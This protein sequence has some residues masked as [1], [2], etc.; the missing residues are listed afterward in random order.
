MSVSAP[1]AAVARIRLRRWASDCV[2][3]ARPVLLTAGSLLVTWVAVGAWAR[4]NRSPGYLVLGGLLTALL[5]QRPQ[6]GLL[7]L[8]VL[9]ATVLPDRSASFSVGGV[10][11]DAVEALSLLLIAVWLLAT[12]FRRLARPRLLAG[13]LLFQVA[14]VVGVLVGHRNGA[15]NQDLLGE[16][17]AYM[18]YTLPLVFAAYFATAQSQARLE[19]WVIA[20][21]DFGAAATML[22]VALG[23]PFI[24]QLRTG[25]VD[26]LGTSASVNRVISPVL[27]LITLGLLFVL[28]RVLERGATPADIARLALYGVAETLGFG[29]STWL[30]LVVGMVLLALLRQGK[31]VPLRGLRASIVIVVLSVGAY[32][33]AASG[34]LGPTAKA[35]A[36]RAAS[37]V[38]PKVTS[39]L[40]Y[41]D[42]QSETREAVKTLGTSPVVGVGLARPYGARRP[43]YFD[44]PPRIVYTDR[45]FV[46]NTYL[47]IW[48]RVGLLGLLAVAILAWGVVKET[49]FAVRT[50][51]PSVSTRHLAAALSLAVMAVSATFQTLL[52][53][54]P[55]ILAIS[56]ALALV[57]RPR[58]E[59][60]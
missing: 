43:L 58:P 27:A 35:A 21:C 25:V 49:V 40:S 60:G 54:R 36:A 31:R 20:L 13:L 12:L 32:G 55:S 47:G 48:L 29:R 14:V 5:V 57:Q 41:A 28:G 24:N 51:P 33:L 45:L 9:G 59:D 6:A 16:A 17:K 1:P 10:R 26:T 15:T 11:S 30:P 19:R 2:V 44:N 7:L 34:S 42:R 52:T 53:Y 56:C 3:H 22:G 23:L 4:G 37:T 50:L 46:H 8:L 18:L 39:E 38:N